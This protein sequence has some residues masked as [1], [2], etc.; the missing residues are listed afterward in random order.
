MGKVGHIA[1]FRDRRCANVFGGKN[2]GMETIG[3]LRSIW[4]DNIEMNLQ[5]YIDHSHGSR[6]INGKKLTTEQPNGLNPV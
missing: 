3:R 5:A 2:W 1:Q 4:V 6:R